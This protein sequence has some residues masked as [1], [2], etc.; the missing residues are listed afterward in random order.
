MVNTNADKSM[1]YFLD[2]LHFCIRE[3]LGMYKPEELILR[4]TQAARERIY[5]GLFGDA[6]NYRPKYIC[7]IEIDVV[8]EIESDLG[9]TVCRR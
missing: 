4:A 8:D 1:L 9:F 5:A 3:M 2:N 7:G 6:K